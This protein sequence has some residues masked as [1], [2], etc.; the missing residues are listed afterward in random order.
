LLH[1]LAKLVGAKNVLEI[2]TF[3]GG[4]ALWMAHAG[5]TVTSLEFNTSYATEA[6]AHV[7]DSPYAQR[8][9]IAQGDA[10]VWLENQPKTSRYDLLFIDAE[11]RSYMKYLDAAL[12]LLQQRALVVADNSLLWGAVTGEDP[13]AASKEATEVMRAFNARL[14]DPEFDGILLPTAEGLTIGRLK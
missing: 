5:A 1:W 7:A 10:L 8:I 2:G 3:M 6:Q 12:P 9:T 11:K 14:A 13:K 4:T